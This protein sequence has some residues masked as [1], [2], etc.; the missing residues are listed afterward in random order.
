MLS[1]TLGQCRQLVAAYLQ[2]VNSDQDMDVTLFVLFVLFVL[3][4]NYYDTAA[5]YACRL[6]K[7]RSQ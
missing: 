1:Q 2:R 5:L 7:R 6:H 3:M 4:V